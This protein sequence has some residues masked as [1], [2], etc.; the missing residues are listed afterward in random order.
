MTSIVPAKTKIAA[1]R[2]FIRT[3][4]QSYGATLTTG[5]SASVITGIATGEVQVVPTAITL[6][7]ALVAP[8]IAGAAS[9]FSILGDGIPEDYTGEIE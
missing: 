2:G 9:Y 6:A 8:V 1:K 3:T 5:I 4:A 7:V